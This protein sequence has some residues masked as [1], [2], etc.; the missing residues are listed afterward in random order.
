VRGP[1]MLWFSLARVGVW[2][3]GAARG[4]P[5]RRVEDRQQL[6]ETRGSACTAFLGRK[7][8]DRPIMGWITT[9]CG[10]LAKK[11]HGGGP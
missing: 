6:Q 5:E 7:F 3:T 9:F 1:D 2:M 11:S 8:P 4:R 10:G